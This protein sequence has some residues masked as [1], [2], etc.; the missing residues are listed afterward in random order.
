MVGVKMGDDDLADVAGRQPQPR[1]LGSHGQ[2]RAQP[3]GRCQPVERV[4][5]MACGRE[6]MGR[7]ARIPQQ[8]AML[9]MAQQRHDGMAVHFLALAP[10]NQD[11]LMGEAVTG[12]ENVAGEVWVAW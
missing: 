4:R 8:P 10:L 6:H 12:V 1:Q 2:F 7:I 9:R 3:Q 11:V 5:E